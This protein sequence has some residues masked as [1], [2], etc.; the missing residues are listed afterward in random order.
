MAVTPVANDKD[1]GY[2][3]VKDH[4]LEKV[5]T[6]I[7][8]T[9][10]YAVISEE[11]LKRDDADAVKKLEGIAKR[12]AKYEGDYGWMSA[13]M[14]PVWQN[15]SPSIAQVQLKCKTQATRRSLVQSDNWNIIVQIPRAISMDPTNRAEKT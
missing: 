7:L 15:K 8:N 13:I 4:D 2:S 5:L 12:I 14:G 9:D 3:L 6:D 10:R 11:K 1:S